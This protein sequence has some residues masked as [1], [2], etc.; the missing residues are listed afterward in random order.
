MDD[1]DTVV[2]ISSSRPLVGCSLRSLGMHRSNDRQVSNYHLVGHAEA[3]RLPVLGSRSAAFKA[4]AMVIAI[5][6]LTLSSYLT[7]PMTPVPI[8]LQTLVVTLV[9]AFFGWRCGAFTIV[10]WLLI[11]ALGL[12]VLANGDFGWTKFTGATGGYLFAFP[13]A[14]AV[15]GWLVEHKGAG[16]HSER[17]LVAMLIGSGICLLFGGAWLALII[18]FQKAWSNGVQPFLVGALIKSVV[19]ALVVKGY[20]L[21]RQSGRAGAPGSARSR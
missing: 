11:G 15:V 7:I 12:P 21:Y 4:V 9:G 10:M 19:G 3:G 5:W 1:S 18:G 17:A 14:A 8:T 13:L 20:N 16:V 6:L 2:A